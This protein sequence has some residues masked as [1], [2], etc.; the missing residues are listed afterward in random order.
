MISQSLNDEG[1]HVDTAEN[2]KRGLELARSKSYDL[3]ISDLKMPDVDGLE[4]LGGL[5]EID[6]D[7]SVII[8]TAYGTVESAVA[9]M[10][11]GAHDFITKPFDPDHLNLLV[12][13]AL[14]NRRLQAENSL[15]KEELA[16]NLGFS[17]I[18]GQNEKMK[19]VS[20]LIQKVAA[21]DTSVLLQ[22][23]SGTGQGAFCAGDS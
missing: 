8:M 7:M 4:V 2:G 5:K 19:E 10:K 15:L 18:I 22:G 6:N 9:A 3:V 20:R 14:E 13:R 21:S 17:E 11:K 12:E 23:E 1:Y 16:Q